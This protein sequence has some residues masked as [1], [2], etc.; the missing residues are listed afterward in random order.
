MDEIRIYGLECYAYHG[1]YEEEKQKGQR[2]VINA[3]PVS[4]THLR[5]HET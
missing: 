4:Y 5:A 3:T 1:V 2:F